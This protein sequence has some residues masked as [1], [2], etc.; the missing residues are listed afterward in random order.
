MKVVRGQR[1]DKDG[2]L[3][4]ALPS[5]RNPGCGRCRGLRKELIRPRHRRQFAGRWQLGAQL[6]ALRVITQARFFL[7]PPFLDEAAQNQSDSENGDGEVARVRFVDEQRHFDRGHDD[8]G[9]EHERAFPDLDR[10]LPVGR[11]RAEI[12]GNGADDAD[13]IEIGEAGHVFDDNDEQHRNDRGEQHA[14]AGYAPFVKTLKDCRQLAIARHQE[15]DRDQIDDG[16]V[17][18]GEKEQ[19]R[20]RR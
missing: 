7:G 12:G 18:R 4:R 15:L 13:G 1:A 17:D 14:G 16:G 19:G 10:K 2:G 20:R 11:G 5:R 6:P 9:P 3:F 8:E